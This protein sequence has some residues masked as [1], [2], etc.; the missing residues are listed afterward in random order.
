MKERK[1]E[2]VGYRLEVLRVPHIPQHSGRTHQTARGSQREV[3]SYSALGKVSS[4]FSI[5]VLYIHTIPVPK[6]WDG[7]RK[8]AKLQIQERLKNTNP[9]ASGLEDADVVPNP[10]F[11]VLGNTL[12]DP[13]D[14]ADLL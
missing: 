7:S 14:V 12:G 4:S 9:L 5:E 1:V 6:L 2:L 3:K 11:L 8:A 10:I 13:S